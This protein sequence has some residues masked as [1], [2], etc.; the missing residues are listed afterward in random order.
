M[1]NLPFVEESAASSGGGVPDLWVA[2]AYYSAGVAGASKPEVVISPTNYQPY[3]RL[4][5]GGGSTDPITDTTN[6]RPYG[7]RVIKSIQ[8]GTIALGAAAQTATA[9]ITAV[10][11]ANTELRFLGF[12]SSGTDVTYAIGILL[13]NTTTIQAY[14][15]GVAGAGT[16]GWELTERY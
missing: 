12:S 9:T 16:V 6:W 10:V 14:K 3:I 4:V 15:T 8:R 13:L 1:S 11:T 7:E 2:G 5:S